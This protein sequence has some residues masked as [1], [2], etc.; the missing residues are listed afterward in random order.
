MIDLRPR[1]LGS[2]LLQALVTVVLLHAALPAG[3]DTVEWR[4][5]PIPVVLS[6]G[7]ERILTFPGAVQVG[8]PQ[9]LS[10][11]EFRSQSTGGT[12]LWLARAPFATE[13][14]Q[15]RFIE[16]GEVMLFDVTA[17][18]GAASEPRAPLEIVLSGSSR[19]GGPV[20]AAAQ[21]EVT[22]VTLTRF[23]A[24]QFFAPERVLTRHP[25]IRRVPMRV[26]EVIHLYR[27]ARLATR[28]LASWQADD[29]FVTAV[30]FRNDSFDRLWLDPRLLRGRFVT[31]TFQQNV[32]GPK[33]ARNA[34]TIAYLVTDV[35]IAEAIVW[36]GNLGSEVPE[37]E[38]AK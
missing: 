35:P 3:A 13:R 2:T 33:D 26:P 16:T 21:A 1:R 15:V 27:D 5:T 9:T 19:S 20:G 24:Q 34:A 23:A 38:A 22:P 32:L 4:H 14:L 36:P 37:D 7:E 29:I 28:A 30:E 6:V 12:V 18:A 8:V 31:A 25:G 11:L 17:V 10:G